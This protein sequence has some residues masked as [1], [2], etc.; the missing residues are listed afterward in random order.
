MH[1]QG[2]ILKGTS[3]IFGTN[4]SLIYSCGI[5][6]S[7]NK[8]IKSYL[9]NVHSCF[10]VIQIFLWLKLPSSLM[11]SCRN[12]IWIC[13]R[14]T[15]DYWIPVL[16]IPVTL[17]SQHC[18]L[19]TRQ[20]HLQLRAHLIWVSWNWFSYTTNLW[21]GRSSVSVRTIFVV[22]FHLAWKSSW[23]ASN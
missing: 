9:S 4:F 16:T 2:S 14:L 21:K 10:G 6:G 13:Q 22:S 15:Q 1:V 20:W 3:D 7:L 19:L 11:I 17:N 12:F 23:S 5:F 8:K 18:K